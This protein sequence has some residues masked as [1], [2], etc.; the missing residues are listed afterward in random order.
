MGWGHSTYK[1]AINQSLKGKVKKVALFHHDPERS[2]AQ[3]DQIKD[4]FQDQ[5]KSKNLEI[6][7][8]Y[9]NQEIEL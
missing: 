4:A 3:L 1:Y 6:F 7:P 5:Y 9:E 8:A 2:D